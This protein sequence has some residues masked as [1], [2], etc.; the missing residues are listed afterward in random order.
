MKA[1]YSYIKV[2]VGGPCES[3][4]QYL[5]ITIA[6]EHPFESKV[7]SH[8]NCCW[9]PL[10]KHSSLLTHFTFFKAPSIKFISRVLTHFSG[11]WGRLWKQIAFKLQLLLGAPLKEKYLHITISV[12][13][14]V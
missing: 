12:E 2:A 7:L 11:C 5:N 1:R 4:V 3:K 9:R 10:C 8:Y 13:G 6:V 14:A